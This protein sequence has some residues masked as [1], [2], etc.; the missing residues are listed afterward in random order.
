MAICKSYSVGFCWMQYFYGDMCGVSSTVHGCARR[1]GL[2]GLIYNLEIN[3]QYTG[4]WI[5]SETKWCYTVDFMGQWQLIEYTKMCEKEIQGTY[6]LTNK[7]CHFVALNPVAQ[8]I[9]VTPVRNATINIAW[10]SYSSTSFFKT[11]LSNIHLF[12][13]DFLHAYEEY[14]RQPDF[15]WVNTLAPGKSVSSDFLMIMPSDECQM[16]LLMISLHWFR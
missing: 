14:G 3:T 10:F 7:P 2:H 15:I 12:L 6:P 4:N 16:T 13:V 1:L 11:L 9:A 8:K 5:R